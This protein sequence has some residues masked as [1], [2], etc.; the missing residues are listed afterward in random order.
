MENGTDKK[1]K[2]CLR[3]NVKWEANGK[4]IEKINIEWKEQKKW[5]Y[6]RE[7]ESGGRGK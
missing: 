7:G 5:E 2:E 6:N 3:G 4:V 1:K